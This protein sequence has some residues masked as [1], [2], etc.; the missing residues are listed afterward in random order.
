MPTNTG[1][2]RL[3]AGDP[4]VDATDVDGRFRGM[5]LVTGGAGFIGAHIAAH[6]VALGKRVRIF[7]N[8]SSGREEN[9]AAAPGAE[10]VQGD[11]RDPRAVRRAMVGVQYVFH[12][13]ADPSVP[14]SMMDPAGCYENNV[15]GTL[16]VL[17]A[18]REAGVHRVV[19]A[20][21]CAVF[22]D[23]PE[24]PKTEATTLAPMS[25][26]AASKLAGE[27]LCQVYTNA[28]G[29]ETVSLR[30][31]N[32]F[33]PRQAPNSVYAPV[34]PDLPPD[35]SPAS[36]QQFTATVSKHATSSLSTTSSKPICEP[37][38]RGGLPARS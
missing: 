24:L 17:D 9:L 5:Y 1:V 15:M 6:L 32:V 23:T 8:L 12:Q 3:Q 28:F 4:D 13:A 31:F 19:F 36:D 11:I 22:G 37:Q 29:L 34:I 27:E 33:G 26:Y 7:D 21:S 2:P 25:P 30:Y 38:P 18:A 35:S 14:R 10:F 16:H 20:S